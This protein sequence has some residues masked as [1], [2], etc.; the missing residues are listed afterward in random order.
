MKILL[1]GAYGQLGTEFRKF[2]EQNNIQYI[3]VSRTKRENKTVAADIT[4]QE[5]MEEIFRNEAIDLLINCAAYNDVDKAEGEGFR[6]AWLTNTFAVSNLAL[7]CRKYNVPMIHFSTDYVF[8]GEK[9]TPYTEED[10][11]MPICRYG[12][13][14]LGGEEFLRYIWEKHICLRVSWVFGRGETNFIKKLL[15]WCENGTVKV[16]TDE[17]SSPT[18][19]ETIVKASWKLFKEKAFGLYHLSNEGECSRYE[20]AKFVLKSLNWKGKLYKAKQS[21]FKLPAKRPNYSKLD[22]SN[23]KKVINLE[24]PHWEEAVYTYLKEEYGI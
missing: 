8:N 24:I 7:I 12:W 5:K 10:K 20:Y 2:F 9:R 17:I 19:T 23:L 3:P 6:N 15:K 4:N 21:F 13:S 16:A 1:T 22:P 18:S 14:K 11:P